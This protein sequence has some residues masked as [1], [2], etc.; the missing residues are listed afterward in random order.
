M[1]Q[2][3]KA[4]LR[5]TSKNSHNTNTKYNPTKLLFISVITDLH[6]YTR[7]QSCSLI[8]F[9][10]YIK[11]FY[12]CQNVLLHDSFFT[13]MYLPVPCRAECVFDRSISF[14]AQFIVCI[15]RI[16]PYLNDIT[17]TA[18]CNLIVKFHA[19]R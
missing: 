16:S 8:V 1:F 5:L 9:S 7:I 4:A 19:C 18:R 11:L 17:C 14:P 15:R 2:N 10:Y 3:K 6:D 12:Y 13:Q